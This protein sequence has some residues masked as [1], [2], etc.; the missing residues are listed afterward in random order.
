MTPFVIPQIL[1]R[2]SILDRA[3]NDTVQYIIHFILHN[4]TT[5]FELQ[6]IPQQKKKREQTKR[7]GRISK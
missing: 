4:R 2:A 7:K 6:N 3:D 5:I 1:N